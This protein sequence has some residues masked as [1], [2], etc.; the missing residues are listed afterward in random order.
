MSEEL[1]RE[2]QIS[3]AGEALLNSSA[4]LAGGAVAFAFVCSAAG[5][6]YLFGYFSTIGA[7]WV[8]ELLPAQVFLQQGAKWVG[9]FASLTWLAM[10]L[11]SAGENSKKF[12]LYLDLICI[13]LCAASVTF[14]FVSKEYSPQ[15]W[16]A[17]AL[18]FLLV[19]FAP[20]IIIKT[21]RDFGKGPLGRVG[22]GF[23]MTAYLWISC[24]FA[25][26]AVSS[27]HRAYPESLGLVTFAESTR[28]WRLVFAFGDYFLLTPSDAALVF[29]D[30]KITAPVDAESI[31]ATRSHAPWA[32]TPK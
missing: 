31:R 11:H 22:V 15:F 2:K 24:V 7:P 25:G 12:L 23:Q 13:I 8:I 32:P 21:T 5:F 26:V 10:M 14:F 20:K 4:S 19:I 3:T 1:E 29:R 27:V 18:S 16:L 9:V 6:A 17:L 30:F 28:E